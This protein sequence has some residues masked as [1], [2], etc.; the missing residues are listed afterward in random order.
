MK[1]IKDK[2]LRKYDEKSYLAFT[3][4]FS[5]YLQSYFPYCWGWMPSFYDIE[6]PVSSD[7][8]NETKERRHKT[9]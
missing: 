8:P 7:L 9:K 4:Y 1:D 2:W 5:N 3:K 6:T